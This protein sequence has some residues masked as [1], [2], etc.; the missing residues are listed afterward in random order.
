MNKITMT[1]LAAA[2]AATSLSAGAADKMM[3]SGMTMSNDM[4]AMDTNGDGMISKDEYMK[5]AEMM[6]EGMQKNKDGM[7]DMKH[8]SMTKGH[9]MAKGDAMMK[10]DPMM[11]SDMNMKGGSMMKSDGPMTKSGITTGQKAPN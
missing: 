4:K 11:K 10:S 8:M 3:K 9:T 2:L 7:V 5:H 1:C 6:F